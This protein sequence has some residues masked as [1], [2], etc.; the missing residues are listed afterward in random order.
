MVFR[1]LRQYLRFCPLVTTEKPVENVCWTV[2]APSEIGLPTAVVCLVVV[3]ESV[4]GAVETAR[5]P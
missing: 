5:L 4:S 1:E 2:S 3:L